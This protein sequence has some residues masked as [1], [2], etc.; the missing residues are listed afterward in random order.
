MFE[1]RDKGC[2]LITINSDEVFTRRDTWDEFQGILLSTYTSEVDEGVLGSGRGGFWLWKRVMISDSL[3]TNSQ[4]YDFRGICLRWECGVK[5]YWFESASVGTTSFY[6]E[7]KRGILT[8]DS[9]DDSQATL[10]FTSTRKMEGRQ[11]DLI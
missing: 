9:W 7:A 2:D 8:W 4:S 5:E 6:W 1:S 11:L 10:W 3:R